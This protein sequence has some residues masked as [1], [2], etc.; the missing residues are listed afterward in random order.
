MTSALQAQGQAAV[1]DGVIDTEGSYAPEPEEAAQRVADYPMAGLE[2]AGCATKTRDGNVVTVHLDGC[3]GPFGRVA[4]DG[5]LVATFS[6]TSSD[7]LRVEVRTGEGTTTNGNPLSYQAYA[8]VRFEGTQRFLTYH[9]NSS[10]TTVRG[11]PFRRETD[12]SVASDFATHCAEI[13]GTSK[14]SVGRYDIDLTIENLKGCRDG[15]P[16]S[17]LARARVDGPLV[18]DTSVE[19]TFD[20][21]EEAHVKIDARRTRE[22]DITLDCDAL[23]TAN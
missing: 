6:K 8:E 14:G 5:A 10:G 19:V 23:E 21:S 1:T 20:G 15:C 9:G 13:D 18:R 17:G 16:T 3:T 12:L 11:R 22:F 4:I 2:P 7:T